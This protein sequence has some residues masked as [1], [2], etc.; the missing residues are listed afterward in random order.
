MFFQL[1]LEGRSGDWIGS[2]QAT[3]DITR[4]GTRAR[5]VLSILLRAEM[6]ALHGIM[7]VEIREHSNNLAILQKSRAKN[8]SYT[9][10]T[11]HTSFSR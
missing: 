3:H 7:N 9:M 11:H 1:L 2:G 8:F 6:L 4:G 10:L 5:H